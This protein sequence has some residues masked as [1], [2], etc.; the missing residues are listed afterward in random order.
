MLLLKPNL[1]RN[2]FGGVFSATVFYGHFMASQRFNKVDMH[3]IFLLP[4]TK[5]SLFVISSGLCLSRVTRIVKAVLHDETGT[6]NYRKTMPEGVWC[7]V[8]FYFACCSYCV[9][10]YGVCCCHY[11]VFTL[12]ACF[13]ELLYSNKG[14]WPCSRG[15][16]DF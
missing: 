9:S 4:G 12:A 13:N 1:T 7:Y 6:V 14:Q 15:V 10:G 16:P 5:N 2:S 3:F 11:T 8:L